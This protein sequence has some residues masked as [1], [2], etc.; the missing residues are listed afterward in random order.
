M[1]LPAIGVLS[2]LYRLLIRQKSMMFA[3]SLTPDGVAL[4]TKVTCSVQLRPIR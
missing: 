2:L 3:Q 1:A 4:L